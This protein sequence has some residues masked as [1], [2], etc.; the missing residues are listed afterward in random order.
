MMSLRS[1]SLLILLFFA[2]HWGSCVR[3]SGKLD[4]GLSGGTLQICSERPLTGFYRDGYC[5]TGPDDEGKHV[6]CARVTREFLAFS[7]L[8]G[9]DL[10]TPTERFPGLHPGDKWC[11]CASRWAEAEKHGVAPPI[12][13]EATP[14]GAVLFVPDEV[15]EQAPMLEARPG[16]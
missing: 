2:L 13:P 9:N 8:Q 7:L 14:E 1:V 11:L 6:I 3:Q 4:R 15:L 5:R 16:L 12:D 10:I